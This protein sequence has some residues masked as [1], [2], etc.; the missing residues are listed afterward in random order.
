MANT[1]R[2][3]NTKTLKLWSFPPISEGKQGRVMTKHYTNLAFLL[4]SNHFSL[5][6]F[7]VYQSGYDNSLEYSERLLKMYVNAVKKGCEY[8]GTTHGLNL[9]SPRL[10][11]NFEWLIQNGFLFN[12]GGKQFLINP[13][14]TYSKLY[15]KSE[16]YKK[17]T[18]SYQCYFKEHPKGLLPLINSY[19]N[20]ARGNYT[21][22]HK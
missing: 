13:S 1:K 11:S 7:L 20:E 6:S 17:W 5:L 15:V 2:I 8:Y 16:F 3:Q 18:E 19:L 14:I 4:N 21:R 10:R 12:I 22:R 9:S